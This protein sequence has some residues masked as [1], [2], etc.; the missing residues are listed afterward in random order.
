MKKILNPKLLP[1]YTVLLSLVGMALR[2]WTVGSGPDEAGLYP[3]NT[4]AWVVMWLFTALTIGLIY[5][6][7]ARLKKTG[8]YHESFSPSLPGAV[9]CIL[10]AVAFAS[11][12][13]HAFMNDA[14][15]LDIPAGLLGIA[16]CVGLLVAG[17]ARLKG[18]QPAFLCHLIPCLFMA[19]H[20]FIQCRRWSNTTQFGTFV[21][22]FLGLLSVMLSL[23]QQT[24]F[25]VSKGCRKTAVLWSL[26]SVYLC[27]VGV[28][29]NDNWPFY[30]GMAVW[31]F[32]NLCSLKPLK[33]K[34]AET[35]DTPEQAPTANID[36][37]P[38]KT[39]NPEDMTMEELQ[40]WLE[41]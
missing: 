31:Q 16:S 7:S 9:G 27:M 23:Y 29:A 32:T 14:T 41:N 1:V 13:I 24:L 39:V 2:L 28:I 36:I 26:C 35:A 5:F 21:F 10:A 18:N 37:D 8:S 12:G 38:P 30:T 3:R 6:T 20:I 17:Y 15:F 19:L 25:D 22:P 34:T 40:D 11:A 4:F 33:R